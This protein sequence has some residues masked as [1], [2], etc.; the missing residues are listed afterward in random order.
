MPAFLLSY[1]VSLACNLYWIVTA[2]ALL[3]FL[4]SLN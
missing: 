1:S 2:L 4:E 3:A